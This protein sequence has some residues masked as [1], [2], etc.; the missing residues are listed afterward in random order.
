MRKL[1]ILAIITLFSGLGFCQ[2]PQPSSADFKKLNWLLGTWTRTNSR[3]G[4]SGQ[5]LWVKVAETSL[6]G[7]GVNL[8]GADTAFVE[9]LKIIVRD[10]GIYYVA[11]IVENKEPVYF[12]FTEISNTSFTCENP[13]HDFPK[14]I[15]YA[16]EGS[17]LKATISGDGKVIDYLFERVEL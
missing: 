5:E 9:K 7:N 2:S 3:P 13:K 12:K 14:K 15:T 10:G 11:D 1:S 17:K 8:K 6:Q 16:L 4:R